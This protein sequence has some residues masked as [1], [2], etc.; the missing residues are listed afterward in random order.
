MVDTG[1]QRAEH[2]AVADDA[3]DRSAAEADAMIGPLAA[4]Q[5]DAVPLTVELVIGQRELQRGVR[6][7][8]SGIAEE[9]VIEPLRRE[10]GDAACQFKGLRNAELERR[11]EIQR[12]GLSGDSRRDLGAAVTGVA[13]P[14]AGGAVEDF[15]AVGGDV[16]HVFGTGE[17]PRR[18]F[19]GAVSSE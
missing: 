19:E 1:E 11:R 10:L 5:A 16:V 6:G 12:L 17:Q 13:A 15:A 8:R 4:N 7:L 14:H 9:Y 3:A 18:L 2:F